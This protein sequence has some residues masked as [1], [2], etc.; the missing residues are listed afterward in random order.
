MLFANVVLAR[1]QLAT[2]HR[3][4]ARVETTSDLETV[5]A[6]ARMLSELPLG[7]IWSA[8]WTTQTPCKLVRPRWLAR[9]THF[10][11]DMMLM[12]LEGFAKAE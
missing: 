8:C 3:S 7:T 11:L 5:Y 6:A 9:G 10:W 12:S 4:V 1:A 2:P